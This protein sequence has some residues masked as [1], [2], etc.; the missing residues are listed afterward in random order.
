MGC[1]LLDA[2]HNAGARVVAVAGHKFF[3][4]G[5]SG[6]VILAESHATIHTYPESSMAYVDYFS[7]SKEP[8]ESEFVET[9]VSAGFEVKANKLERQDPPG[10]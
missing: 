4:L 9:F 3:P 8:N 7:C 5:Y 6:A 10:V 1:L 2:C